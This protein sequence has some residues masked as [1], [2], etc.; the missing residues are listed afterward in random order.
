MINVSDN[1]LN[2]KNSLLINGKTVILI[3]TSYVI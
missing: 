2:K 3:Q 1:N